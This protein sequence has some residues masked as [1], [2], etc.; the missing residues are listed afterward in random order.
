MGRGAHLPDGRNQ[1][2][3]HKPDHWWHNHDHRHHRVRYL[4]YQRRCSNLQCPC[5]WRR[6][7]SVVYNNDRTG[8]LTALRHKCRDCRIIRRQRWRAW[9]TSSAVLS[10]PSR[11]AEQFREAVTISTMSSSVPQRHCRIVYVAQCFWCCDTDGYG[12]AF[13]MGPGGTANSQ[14]NNINLYGSSGT[15]SGSALTFYRNG[16]ARWGVGELFFADRR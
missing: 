11:L 6:F 2:R 13:N 7:A 5:D 10:L 15:G 8:T 3:D 9:F 14:N 16:T 12:N 1:H 4:R